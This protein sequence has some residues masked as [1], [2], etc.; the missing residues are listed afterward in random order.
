MAVKFNIQQLI[1]VAAQMRYYPAVGEAVNNALNT[2]SPIEYEAAVQEATSLALSHEK[3]SRGYKSTFGLPLY[4]PFEFDPY[5]ETTEGLIL[6]SA[7]CSISRS[8]NIVITELQGRDHSV[9]EFINGGDFEISVSGIICTPGYGYPLEAVKDFHS[10]MDQNKSM[11]IIHEVLNELGV[12]DI[13]ITGYELPKTPYS[14]CQLY[15]F[16]AVSDLPI[17]LTINE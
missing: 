2:S 15:S 3:F 14:N 8:K 16:N 5:D 13:V 12:F 6:E 4:L 1:G 17:E 9:K 11:R 7:V 10:Y